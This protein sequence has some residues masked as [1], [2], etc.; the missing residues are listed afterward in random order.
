ISPVHLGRE[1]RLLDGFTCVVCREG[2]LCN[3]DQLRLDALA[4]AE[5]AYDHLGSVLAHAALADSTQYHR[6]EQVSIRFHE[7]APAAARRLQSLFKRAMLS[8]MARRTRNRIICTSE[9]IY[10]CDALP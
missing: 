4:R 7:I 1:V 8:K 10:A 5:L 3:V 2:K 9:G 6:N